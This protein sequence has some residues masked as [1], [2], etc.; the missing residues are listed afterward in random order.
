MKAR[1]VECARLHTPMYVP[2]IGELGPSL[3]HKNKVIAGFAMVAVAEGLEVYGN[4][5]ESFVPWSNVQ[6][7]TYEA[8]I[9]EDK[10]SKA[11]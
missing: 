5:K 1:K 7:V 11:A 10:K 3:P 2:G 8:E 6:C 4:N 9:K